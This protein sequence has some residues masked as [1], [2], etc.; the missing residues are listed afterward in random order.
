MGAQHNEAFEAVC[1]NYKEQ[2]AKGLLNNCLSEKNSG[3]DEY[4]QP[5]LN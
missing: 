1:S 3:K 2:K 5:R 4:S